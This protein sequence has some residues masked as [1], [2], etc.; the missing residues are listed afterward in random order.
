MHYSHIVSEAHNDHNIL[1]FLYN[2]FKFR[3]INYANQPIILCKMPKNVLM[4]EN[5]CQVLNALKNY[6]KEYID[7]TSDERVYK[8]T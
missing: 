7:Y 3:A 6:L 2:M 5:R 1:Y 8:I 4:G